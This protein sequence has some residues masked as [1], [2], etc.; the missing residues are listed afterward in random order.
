[1]LRMYS[2]M[3]YDKRDIVILM[4]GNFRAFRLRCSIW[5]ISQ[6]IPWG[7]ISLE[8]FTLEQN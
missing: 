4:H 2:E 1:M 8:Q 6:V 3:C 7:Q 5:H